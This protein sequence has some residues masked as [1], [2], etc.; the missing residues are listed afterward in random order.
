M[1]KCNTVVLSAER[2]PEGAVIIHERFSPQLP[3]YVQG[4]RCGSSS[5]LDTGDPAANKSDTDTCPSQ[6]VGTPGRDANRE[7]KC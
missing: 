1:L 3:K 7:L 6:G 5:V 2:G 4:T